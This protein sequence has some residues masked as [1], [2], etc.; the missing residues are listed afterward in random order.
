MRT[1]IIHHPYVTER[2]ER[3][4]LAR[5]ADR[6]GV[7]LARADLDALGGG[8]LADNTGPV[9]LNAYGAVVVFVAF[10]ALR[11]A[12]PINWDGFAGLRVLFDHDIIQNYSDIFRTDLRGLWP[13]QFRRHR[14]DVVFTSGGRVRDRLLDDGVPAEW[15]PK[16]FEPSRFF[17]RSESRDG[18]AT[19]GSA[20]RCRVAAEQ[21]LAEA[22]V[23]VHRLPTTPYPQL[24]KALSRHL[25]CLAISSDLLDPLG[26][27]PARRLRIRPGLEPMAKLFEAAGAGCCPVADAMDDL[28]LLGFRHGETV[29]N[30]DSHG[31]LVGLMQD[32]LA[33]PDDLR[34]LGA[35]AAA[36]V[37][38]KHTWAH[39]AV[40]FEAAIQ[41]RLSAG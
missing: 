31:V 26:S 16:A 12:H 37:H 25:A 34:A 20:Y 17:D 10:N 2:F 7:S 41:R 38:A 4:F 21:A 6:P 39:R 15:I 22:G 3:D 28:T 33:R 40:E 23:P 11:V 36:F 35:A 29:L 27:A 8:V 13:E 24:G 9:R 18:L 1:L 30:F 14:F 32:W 19:Y 5:L